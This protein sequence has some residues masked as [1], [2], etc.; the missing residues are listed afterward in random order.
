[1]SVGVLSRRA[2]VQ[3][4]VKPSADAYVVRMLH[5][6]NI[7][8]TWLTTYNLK[9][10][11]GEFAARGDGDDVIAWQRWFEAMYQGLV[12]GPDVWIT[13]WI[14]SEN[15]PS[16]RL[17]MYR[18]TNVAN[19]QSALPLSARASLGKVLEQHRGTGRGV[20][21]GNSGE[22]DMYAGAGIGTT[23][24]FSNARELPGTTFGSGGTITTPGTDPYGG[25]P[26]APGWNYGSPATWAYLASRGMT[27]VRLP[28]RWERVQRTLGG[29]LDATEIGRIDTALG[30]AAANGIQVILDLHNGGGVYSLD[31]GTQGVAQQIG[32]ATVT[33]AHFSDVWSRITTHFD[34]NS[35]VVAYELC[36]EPKAISTWKT[37][38]AQAGL[39][40][41]RTAG[42]TKTVLVSL[43][44][45]G[46]FTDVPSGSGG[47][48]TDPANNIRYV[49]HFYANYVVSGGSFN[50]GGFY[51][52]YQGELASAKTAG[53]TGTD[54]TPTP[55]STPYVLD[56]FT[57]PIASTVLGSTED[58]KPA[59]W[60]EFNR[61]APAIYGIGYSVIAGQARCVG[62]GNRDVWACV[63]Y[64]ASD[65]TL[66]VDI[67]NVGS[68]TPQAG[69]VVRA[70]ASGADGI[71]IQL[72]T[73]GVNL[74]HWTGSAW[75]YTSLG[76]L[77]AGFVSGDHL[78][79]IGR[80]TTIT[81]KRVHLGVA[82]TL[83]TFTG[84]TTNQTNTYHGLRTF[85]S[86]GTVA[87]DNFALSP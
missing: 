76:S 21:L 54:T 16:H 79:V 35:A 62:T 1:M 80:G 36:N 33:D 26:Y 29:S 71:W 10:Y 57:R 58:A 77:T 46:N 86:D 34:S 44:G 13:P 81:V 25:G 42:S 45:W 14:C 60:I 4:R 53:Y 18:G 23:Y 32:G 15:Y 40:A 67:P 2:V 12:G 39:T 87:W 47:Y 63:N 38:T 70:S 82:T 52:V 20:N 73:Y 83:G 55:A 31:N 6:L 65:F 69:V 61:G 68:S 50:D 74:A 5:D 48:V 59:A 37:S 30:Y 64:G 41:I 51:G 8:L 22:A 43:P 19:G 17:Q 9:G 78:T 7:F 56:T 72:P 75:N 11:I 3:N 84:V 28:F 66:D 85:G 27:L 49:F 24:G